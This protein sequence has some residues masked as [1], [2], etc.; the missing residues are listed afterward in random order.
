MVLLHVD[1]HGNAHVLQQNQGT[2]AAFARP[3]PDGRHLAFQ[4]F[5]IEGN[6]WTLENF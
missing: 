4:D 1:L 3:S 6:I 2:A 5:R